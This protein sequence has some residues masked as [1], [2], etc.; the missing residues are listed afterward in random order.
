MKVYTWIVSVL[1]CIIAGHE[2]QILDLDFKKSVVAVMSGVV[3]AGILM[4]LASMGVFGAF[5]ALFSK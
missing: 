5:G 2:I 1:S 3:L 4:G